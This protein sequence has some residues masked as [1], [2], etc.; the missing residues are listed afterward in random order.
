MLPF[1]ANKQAI[2][3]ALS[4]Q[5]ERMLALVRRRAR[6]LDAE[7][8]LQLASARAV[9]KSAQLQDPTK[10]E[11]W[12]MRIVRTTMLDELRKQ[13]PTIP[14]EDHHLVTT[15]PEASPCWCVLS[16]S[17]Q[18]KPEY[19]EILRRVDIEETPVHLA[20]KALGLTANNAM[21][22]LHRARKT[23]RQQMKAHCGTTSAR[24]CTDCGCE[25]R[26]CCPPP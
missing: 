25:E 3:E 15:E 1:E 26:G 11:A 21:V 8:V 14:I 5:R 13:R 17:T 2:Q 20:A 16:Q 9:L 10:A 22:R 7:D 19:Q 4:T 12:V 6:D 18:M 23:L 24:S